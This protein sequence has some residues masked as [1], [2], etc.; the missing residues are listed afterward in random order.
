[1]HDWAKE[2][3]GFTLDGVA[4]RRYEPTG[5]NAT[6]L[7]HEWARALNSLRQRSGF[8]EMDANA[9]RE[10]EAHLAELSL[11]SLGSTRAQSRRLPRTFV[12]GASEDI[13]KGLTQYA[14]S[15][16]GFLSRQ[17]Y[18]PEIDRVMKE[19]VE[20]QDRH[21][22]EDTSRTYPRGQILKELQQRIFRE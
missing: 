14:G 21:A 5:S 8:K 11:S 12:K 3:V 15:M 20:Y 1:A 9:R 22:H 7:S 4:P 18:M 16:S 10:L 17:Q 19:M 2:G 6:F 13:Q